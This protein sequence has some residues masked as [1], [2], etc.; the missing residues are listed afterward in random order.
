LPVARNKINANNSTKPFKIVAGGIYQLVDTCTD[1]FNPNN[2]HTGGV[3]GTGVEA[4]FGA[5]HSDYTNKVGTSALR[6]QLGQM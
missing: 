5:I 2:C 1:Q 4:H 6:S 3:Y